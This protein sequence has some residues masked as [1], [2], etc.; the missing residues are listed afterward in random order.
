MPA[1]CLVNSQA[2]I[3]DLAGGQLIDFVIVT[4]IGYAVIEKTVKAG[5]HPPGSAE[6]RSRAPFADYFLQPV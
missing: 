5:E 1:E 6:R 2:K 3:K 4:V